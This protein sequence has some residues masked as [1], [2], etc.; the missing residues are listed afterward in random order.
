MKIKIPELSLVFL[1][2]TS[3]SGKS[4]FARKHFKPTEILSS[5]FFRAMVSDD[6]NDQTVTREA[7]EILH[8][9][10]A[11]RLA[12]AR[13]TVADATNV[14]HEARRSLLA[15]AHKYHFLPV[16]LV[17]NLPLNIS[18]ER[19]R[20]RSDR[21]FDE[22]IIRQQWENLQ[23]SVPRLKTEGFRRIYVMETPGE[24]NNALI[25]R[26]P[27]RSNKKNEHGP[28][29]IIGDIHGCFDELMILIKKLGYE[30]RENRSSG[31]EEFTVTHPRG[32]KVIFLG[33]L[34]DR[35]PRIVPV[36]HLAM[37]MTKTGSAFCVPGNH[38]DRLMRK[39]SGKHVIVSHGLEQTL[40]QMKQEPPVFQEKV[41]R[42]VRGLS[43]H[44]VFDD[45]K[46]VVAHAG[47]KAEM[48]GRA[49]GSVR[50]FA[51]FG[52]TSGET[53]VFGPRVHHN[54]AARY[55]GKAMV[56][57]G[58]TPVPEPEWLNNTINIDTGCVFGGKLTALRYPEKEIVSVP[59]KQTYQAPEG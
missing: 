35:G 37:L 45:G 3:G 30:I 29:D 52:E 36:L 22:A 56:V 11:K 47:M 33:D 32:R 40:E 27:L 58:H 9:I 38:E 24:I 31:K 46:L 57:Y 21:H 59:A 54:W 18:L 48:Q 5:D 17:L 19:H 26:E 20:N 49:S 2:G 23:N 13:L 8:S 14:Q 55:R 25:R 39:F 1:I 10:A 4:T 51:F 34:V 7:F 16:A 12:K 28:F 6:E 43:A 50:H 44:Y 15:L 42:F 41:R 53:D